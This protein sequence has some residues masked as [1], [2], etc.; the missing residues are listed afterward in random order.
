M[1]EISGLL[2]ALKAYS[3]W[4]SIGLLTW[5]RNTR[6]SSS[7]VEKCSFVW[8]QC[9]WLE[10]FCL[11]WFSEGEQLALHVQSC[12]GHRPFKCIHQGSGVRLYHTLWNKLIKW[13]CRYHDG[14]PTFLH[15]DC[16]RERNPP[17]YLLH[18]RLTDIKTWK[19]V[20]VTAKQKLETWKLPDNSWRQSPPD[21]L[22][23]DNVHKEPETAMERLPPVHVLK[24]VLCP[25]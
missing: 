3:L 11:G 24:S 23:G 18:T 14:G 16:Q 13:F 12:F 8:G 17:L 15:S 20:R 25:E 5:T 2:A 21:V 22:I 19:W 6:R 4:H 1:S 7:Y 9:H 10:M